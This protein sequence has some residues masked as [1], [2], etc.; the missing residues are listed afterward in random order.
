MSI[1]SDIET[2]EQYLNRAKES[3]DE[4]PNVEALSELLDALF[5][6]ENY[7]RDRFCPEMDED[8][9]D[10]PGTTYEDGANIEF[11]IEAD[12]WHDVSKAIRK[13]KLFPELDE[14]D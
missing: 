8:F 5:V 13:L 6:I 9:G 2:A 3:L 7:Y 4:V 12:W 1:K 10:D 14:K 11:Y